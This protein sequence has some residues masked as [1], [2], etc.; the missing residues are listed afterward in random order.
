L[1]SE[2]G[3]GGVIENIQPIFG[4]DVSF[5]CPKV[6]N[7]A[8]NV[9]DAVVQIAESDLRNVQIGGIILASIHNSLEALKDGVTSDDEVRNIFR[10][11]L[12]S[13]GVNVLLQSSCEL[14][15]NE[16]VLVNRCLE[17]R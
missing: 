9:D 14:K 2:D 12:S 10:L 6:C 8:F 17:V 11:V 4:R 3:V 7:D 5:K 15:T 1:V 13:E 16:N